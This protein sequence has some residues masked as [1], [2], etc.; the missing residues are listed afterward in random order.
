MKTVVEN[1]EEVFL[2]TFPLILSM[3]ESRRRLFQQLLQHA[4]DYVL[5]LTIGCI[6]CENVGLLKLPYLCLAFR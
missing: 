1:L 3:S 2:F 4:V 6:M 5:M